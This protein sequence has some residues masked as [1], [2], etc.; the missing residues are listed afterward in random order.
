ML[1]TT[2]EKPTGKFEDKN[3]ILYGPPKIGKSTFCSQLADTLMLDTEDGLRSLTAY[4]V[5]IKSWVD[6]L[7]V[8]TELESGGHAFKTLGVDTI[9]KLYEFCD[10]FVCNKEHITDPSDKE[11]G[12]G[13]RAVKREF[14]KQ[15]ARLSKL[16]IGVVFISHAK[17][18]ENEELGVKWIETTMPSQASAVI[19]PMADFILY[20]HMDLNG[21][22]I[23]GTRPNLEYMAGTRGDKDVVP[24]PAII[25]L[26]VNYFIKA[27][28][29]DQ[30]NESPDKEAMDETA[31]NNLVG[32]ITKGELYLSSNK[33]D[34]FDVPTRVENARKKYLKADKFD[35]VEFVDLQT[36]L[37]YLRNK[38]KTFI[39]EKK[40]N[41]SGKK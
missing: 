32:D 15:I 12:I 16:G 5:R 14:V 25:P 6:F 39:R 8:L 18:K 11:Y 17:K 19:E 22:R 10:T 41:G 34:G 4:K 1:P 36:Y 27:F 2:K 35:K 38:A 40:E 21:D 33:V 29:A 7:S 20:A 23:I 13:W 31:H 3:I 30:S 24:L 37:Q 28:Y 9:D 26:D